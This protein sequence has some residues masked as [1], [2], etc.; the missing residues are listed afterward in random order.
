ML[1]EGFLDGV[2][3]SIGLVGD[4]VMPAVA[5]DLDRL[6]GQPKVRGEDLKRADLTIPHARLV[7]DPVVARALATQAVVAHR[8]LGLRDYSRSDFRALAASP[9]PYFLETNSMPG[10]QDFQSVLTWAA[11]QA[12]IAYRDV[13]GSIVALALRRLKEAHRRR[14]DIAPFEEAYRRLREGA[15][16]SET[17]RVGGGEYHLLQ[18]LAAE[19]ET[20][21]P[22][23]ATAT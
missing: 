19:E 3:Y 15:N 8:E 11:G 4:V 2:E 20:S 7:R 13:I 1:V 5:W 21:Q 9:A 18:P 10:L 23:A 16:P 17:I 12:G 14:L 22:W 6:P